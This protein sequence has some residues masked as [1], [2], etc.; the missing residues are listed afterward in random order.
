MPI[1]ATSPDG[2]LHQFPDGTSDAE[3]DRMMNEYDET[4]KDKSTTIGEMGHG[5]FD[6]VEGSAQLLE[7]AAGAV[8]A[9]GGRSIP[10]DVNALNNQ[11]SK[12]GLTQNLPEQGAM[13]EHVRRREAAIEQQ[14]GANAGTTD[15]P[16]IA[17]NILSPMNYIGTAIGPAAKAGMTA[18]ERGTTLM[19][20]AEIGGAVAGA[21][22][23]TTSDDF[24]TSKGIQAGT[25]A[26]VGAALGGIGAATEAGVRKVG[27]YIAQK[28]PENLTNTAVQKI[29]RRIKQGEKAGGPSATDI[30]DLINTAKKPVTMADVAG[31]GPRALAGN[32][33]R[34]PG[35]SRDIATN[36]LNKRDEGAADRLSSDINSFVTGGPTSTAFQATE[37]LQNARRAAAKPAY[38]EAYSLQGVWSPRLEEF[39]REPD[40]QKGLHRGYVMERR[41]AVA[42]GRAITST[43]LGVDL[44]TEGNIKLLDKP[45]MRLLDMAKQ[46]LDAMVADSRDKLTGRLSADGLSLDHLRRSFVKVIDDLDPTGAYAKA[47]AE[48][49]GFSKNLDALHIGQHVFDQGWEET[50]SEIAAMSPAE[51][52][53]G[54]LGVADK[55]RDRLDMA[56]IHGDEA[57]R[58]I[59]S[60]KAKK[61]LRPW[62]RTDEE[63]NNF[64]DA[65]TT[66]TKMFETRKNVL[67]GSD[68]ARR[69]MED[70]STDDTP[71][72][73]GAQAI[74]QLIKGHP[75][76]AGR[77]LYNMWRDL[78][79]KPNPELNEKLAE[80]LFATKI[81][82]DIQRAMTQG[83]AAIM[84][85][86]QTANA[87]AGAVRGGT[88]AAAPIATVDVTKERSTQQ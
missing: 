36:F 60:N 3:V 31:E 46:G 43:Q 12:W 40:V 10:Q 68:S 14:R 21:E 80:L 22:Q 30:I 38:D 81:P 71:F 2:K 18:V 1:S 69:A 55:L 15:W 26:V 65:V 4:Q 64:V 57:K 28:Y 24:W 52:E 9:F 45:N 54:R 33:A 27:E 66:E 32:V 61:Q 34:Q 25:G 85:Q 23:T 58:L 47:R 73:T 5:A 86:N 63:F 42:D 79:L 82:E 17:G 49:A 6:P 88:Q 87:V 84:K 53:F 75:V 51:R 59:N 16:R 67:G 7:H 56:G 41:H 44:D 39:L 19:E 11:L 13:D 29:L 20:G 62:F 50:A 77:T 8:P 48:Y 83:S 78:G 37:V 74:E 76:M 70:A 35:A 72:T